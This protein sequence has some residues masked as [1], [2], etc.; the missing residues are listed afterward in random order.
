MNSILKFSIS[1][2]SLLTL[3]IG[4]AFGQDI[5]INNIP[6]GR[7]LVIGS[8][9]IKRNAIGF[10]EYVKRMDEYEVKLGYHPVTRFYHVYIKGYPENKDGYADVKKMRRQTEFIDVWFYIVEP[11]YGGDENTSAITQPAFEPGIDENGG[12]KE[13]DTKDSSGW[14]RAKSPGAADEEAKADSLAVAETGINKK[15]SRKDKKTS[16]KDKKRKAKQNIG[17]EGER[18]RF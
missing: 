17:T 6:E 14:I 9:H 16:R 13:E 5:K 7:F 18:D 10:S 1:Y 2:L 8:F 3:T 15:A 12:I 11:Y 4:L